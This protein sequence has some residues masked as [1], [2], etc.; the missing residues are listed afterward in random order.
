MLNKTDIGTLVEI[1]GIDGARAALQRSKLV[2][3]AQLRAIAERDGFMVSSKATRAEIIDALILPNERRL[4]RTIPELSALTEDQVISYFIESGCSSMEL[5]AYLAEG[6]VPFDKG[7]TKRALITHAAR[8]ISR[9][10]LYQ[11][12]ARPSDFPE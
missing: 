3:T 10:G 12:I 1:V 5:M 4:A 9:I 11:R 8:E 2:T 6:G 7:L